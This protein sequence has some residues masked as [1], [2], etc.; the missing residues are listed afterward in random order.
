MRVTT[1]IGAGGMVTVPSAFRTALGLRPGDEV[2]MVLK[3]E[4]VRLMT[5]ART[6][7]RAQG[8]RP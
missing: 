4:E 2:V 3:D 5:P 8:D 7:R 1:K 6:I